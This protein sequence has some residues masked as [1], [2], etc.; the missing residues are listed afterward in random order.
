M[1]RAVRIAIR[2]SQL[3]LGL[4]CR[5]WL[6]A[7]TK[8]HLGCSACRPVDSYVDE[9]FAGRCRKARFRSSVSTCSATGRGQCSGMPAG[10]AGRTSGYR[11][12]VVTRK[13]RC[14]RHGVDPR[15]S[16]WRSPAAVGVAEP[17]QPW[18]V[19]LCWTVCPLPRG[20]LRAE[21]VRREGRRD[22]LV[23][24]LRRALPLLLS[25]CRPMRIRC[26]AR[27]RPA[28]GDVGGELAA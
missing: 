16:G 1:R 5:S 18:R 28:P 15:W 11:S 6:R 2:H 24:A 17:A 23:A 14:E 12:I 26:R 22:A 8:R 19:L 27:L 21:A 3:P 7:G 9:G 10:S 25:A 13:T 20:E 4:A